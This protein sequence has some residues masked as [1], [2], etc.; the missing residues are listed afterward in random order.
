M[1]SKRAASSEPENAEHERKRQR[2]LQEQDEKPQALLQETLQGEVNPGDPHDHVMLGYKLGQG[3]F[4][5]VYR[6]KT[7]KDAKDVAV[8]VVQMNPGCISPLLV[9]ELLI[10][11]NYSHSNMTAYMDSFIA[12]GNLWLM[13]EYVDGLS[14]GELVRYFRIKQGVMGKILKGVLQ[15]L[16]YLHGCNII[17]RDIKGDNILLG[18]NGDVKLSDYGLSIVEGAKMKQGHGT[19]SFMAP[20]LLTC[21]N[22]TKKIDIWSLGM[23]LAE[24]IKGKQPYSGKS[25]ACKERL[26]ISHVMPEIEGENYLPPATRQF[27]RSCLKKNASERASASQLLEQPLIRQAASTQQL[28]SFVTEAQSKIEEKKADLGLG[29][30]SSS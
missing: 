27:L 26:I 18:S 9:H 24:M 5:S 13:M 4:G 12:E 1:A 3:G 28:A 14:L 15:A 6:G 22:Y 29:L 25:R 23:T 2:I 10:L 17:H 20:E 8:K 21:T 30:L 19:L 11:K 7:T 16:E